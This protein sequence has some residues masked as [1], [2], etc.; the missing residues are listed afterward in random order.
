LFGFSHVVVRGRRDRRMLGE[1][2]VNPFL[3]G[4]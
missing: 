4:T 3:H 2:N 1:D